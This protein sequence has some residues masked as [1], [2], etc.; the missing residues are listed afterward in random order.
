MVMSLSILSYSICH[1]AVTGGDHY[2]AATIF[3]CVE[4]RDGLLCLHLMHIASE[5]FSAW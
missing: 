2:T 5:W 3:K 1:D 4:D